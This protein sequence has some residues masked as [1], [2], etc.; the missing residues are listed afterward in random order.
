MEDPLQAGADAKRRETVLREARSLLRRAER[1]KTTT[2]GIDDE[3]V[4]RLVASVTEDLHRLVRHL[5]QLDRRRT[6]LGRR[7]P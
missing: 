6:A 4:L 3:E 7:T 1:F 2:D 5:V